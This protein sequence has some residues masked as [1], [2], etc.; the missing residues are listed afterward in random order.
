MPKVMADSMLLVTK[1]QIADSQNLLNQ[2]ANLAIGDSILGITGG[3]DKLLI[4]NGIYHELGGLSSIDKI[5]SWAMHTD[6]I[7]HLSISS[8]NSIYSDI[9][10]WATRIAGLAGVGA[11]IRVNDVLL[12]TDKLG[13][14]F[15]KVASSTCAG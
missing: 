14:F 15:L 10:I 8:D 3:D 5:E 9:P 12:G 1:R 11:T 6:E 4:V 13:H 2:K 7:E